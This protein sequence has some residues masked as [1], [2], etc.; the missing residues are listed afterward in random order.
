[1][2]FYEVTKHAVFKNACL[3]LWTNEQIALENSI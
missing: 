1:M 3:R 2:E